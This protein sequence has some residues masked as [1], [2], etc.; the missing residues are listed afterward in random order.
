M[1]GNE[2]CHHLVADQLID[3]GVVVEEHVS[4]GFVEAV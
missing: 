4:G 3:H 2:E 1:G